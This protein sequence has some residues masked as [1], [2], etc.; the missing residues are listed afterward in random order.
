[1]H[2]GKFYKEKEGVL[3]GSYD[4]RKENGRGRVYIDGEQAYEKQHRYE[5]GEEYGPR[6]DGQRNQIE[7]VATV[8]KDAVPSPDCHHAGYD[9]RKDN[10]EVF[11][12]HRDSIWIDVGCPLHPL[13]ERSVLV[14]QKNR[15]E[16][17]GQR[18]Q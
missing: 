7:V 9:H 15:Y 13:Q 4:Q 18:Q 1:M 12:G 17:A 8:G 10:E 3:S 16:A 11:V 14:E 5:V 2:G 6:G